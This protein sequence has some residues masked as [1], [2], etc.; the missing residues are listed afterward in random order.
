M[1]Y[2]VQQTR[3]DRLIRRVSGSI[4]PGSRVSETISEL[5]PVI[6]VERVPGELLL[7]SGTA[8]CHGSGAVTGAVG[9]IPNLILFNPPDSEHLI[10]ITQIAVEAD[11]AGR[12]R[13]SLS[14]STS[15]AALD[16]QRFREGRLVTATTRP[17][18]QVRSLSNPS[19]IEQ[20]V[21]FDIL[22]NVSTF[23]SDENGLAILS[24][25]TKYSVATVTIASTIRVT[26]W[27][28]ERPA[29]VSELQF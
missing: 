11:V 5:F 21:N 13:C 18:G 20:Q 12:I 3:W 8:L 1:T 28:R 10:T 9:E 7:L 14:L 16:T 2:E 25:D 29:Q 26:F 22:A 17:V 19:Q 6:D 24:P 15:G 27:W 4:G 23:F